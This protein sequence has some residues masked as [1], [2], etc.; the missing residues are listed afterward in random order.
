M[1]VKSVAHE[2]IDAYRQLADKRHL[3][4]ARDETLPNPPRV[5]RAGQLQDVACSI[6]RQ[7][8][9]E[10]RVVSSAQS[11]VRDTLPVEDG[12]PMH[13][14]TTH[15]MAFELHKH[16]VHAAHLH[17]ADGRGCCRDTH[18]GLRSRHVVVK[19][20]E[21]H[22][23]PEVLHGRPELVEHDEEAHQPLRGARCRGAHVR[24]YSHSAEAVRRE[25][26]VRE[27]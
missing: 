15:L 27:N 25:L 19:D 13:G 18:D 26:R 16:H 5:L 22:R 11:N 9:A 1:C 21:G 10:D 12:A 2:A 17:P 7:Q 4:H 6:C 14:V 3:G 20:A 23:R 8:E 24:A